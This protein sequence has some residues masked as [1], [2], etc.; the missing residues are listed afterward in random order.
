LVPYCYGVVLLQCGCA[1]CL[2]LTP[3]SNSLKH[4]PPKRN[5]PLAKASVGR[6]E[7]SS[8][9]NECSPLLDLVTLRHIG[10]DRKQVFFPFFQ[11]EIATT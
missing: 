2:C 10:Q 9:V 5:I 8:R 3:A 7:P 1:D 6:C 4:L 11:H